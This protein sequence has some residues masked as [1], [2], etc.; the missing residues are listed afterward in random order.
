MESIEV[1]RISNNSHDHRLLQSSG[2]RMPSTQKKERRKRT[3]FTQMQLQYLERKFAYQKYLTVAD[4][5]FVARSL[6]LSETQV[7][8]W[9]QNRRTKWKRQHNCS[10]IDQEPDDQL[11]HKSDDPNV[12]PFPR[13]FTQTSNNRSPTFMYAHTFPFLK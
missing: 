5:A 6:N 7:K 10:G 4:R 3:A 1:D 11:I 9:Y 12:N 13:D 8:T 2:S